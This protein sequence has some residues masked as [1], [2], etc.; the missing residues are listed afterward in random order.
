MFCLSF[1][2]RH[3]I[4]FDTISS[5]LTLLRSG[6]REA[7]RQVFLDAMVAVE[8]SLQFLLISYPCI[9]IYNLNVT[10]IKC[11]DVSC[12]A[13]LYKKKSAP[14]PLNKVSVK[15]F[16]E[17]FSLISDAPVLFGELLASCRP[18]DGPGVLV[19][20]TSEVRW[21][22]FAAWLVKLVCRFLTEGTL[23]VEGLVSTSFVYKACSFLCYGDATLH[24]VGELLDD[25]SVFEDG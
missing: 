19:D 5:L 24:M 8:G 1:R 16:C 14:V 18:P 21:Q 20:L 17:S 13:L 10:R 4:I 12:I 22:H 15:C 11:T 25:S 6:D 3:G 7:Y 2:V 23:Y 9:S